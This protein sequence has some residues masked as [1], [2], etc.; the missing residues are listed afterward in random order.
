MERMKLLIDFG[1]IKTGGALQLATN[2]LEFHREYPQDVAKVYLLLA[3]HSSLR[4]SVDFSQYDGYLI[5]PDNYVSRKLFELT[6]LRRFI[7]SAE[8]SH[9]YTF[10]GAGIPTAR[11]VR[12]IVS[13]AYPIVCYPDSPFWKYLRF[14]IRIKHQLLNRFRRHRIRL[15]D[16]VIAE[17]EVM[18]NRIARY[19]GVPRTHITVIPPAPTAFVVA[20]DHKLRSPDIK[21]RILLLGGLDRHKNLWRLPEISRVIAS[22]GYIN[23]KFV[24][25]SE[26]ELFVAAYRESRGYETELEQFFEFTGAISPQAIQ[27][28]YDDVH[29]LMNISDLESFSNNYMEAWKAGI[30]LIC[31]DTDFARHIC[32][33][34][35]IYIDPHDPIAGS[36]KIIAF[37]EDP[38]LQERLVRSGKPLLA[39][40]PSLSRKF[41][42][43]MKVMVSA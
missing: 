12:S 5:Y 14:D 43:T 15:A 6:K 40:L 3:E 31:S 34:S 42:E 1:S 30:P 16:K 10:F 35:A 18:A 2:F 25:S 39:E 36:K 11:G 9:I 29:C 17:T 19:V 41:E 27:S 32:R 38:D 24:I 22:Q 28:V 13:V 37:I 4:G 23:F 21:F 8:I 26:R 20:V 33:D 7:R